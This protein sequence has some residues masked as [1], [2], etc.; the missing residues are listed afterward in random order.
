M[1]SLPD[2]LSVSGNR[3]VES[4]PW[5]WPHQHPN[6][7]QAHSWLYSLG[8]SNMNLGDPAHAAWFSP[9][10]V[11][12]CAS[13][14]LGIPMLPTPPQPCP[15]LQRLRSGILLLEAFPA[16]TA[17]PPP[18]WANWLSCVLTYNPVPAATRGRSHWIP[19]GSAG[20]WSQ[21]WW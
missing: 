3:H 17:P 6:L 19:S 14:L 8:A 9:L 16:P 11:F 18:I 5:T 1:I 4:S 13:P 15:C 2:T 12:D 20:A 10:W 21:V 7:S